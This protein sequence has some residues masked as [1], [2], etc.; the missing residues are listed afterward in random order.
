MTLNSIFRE[1]FMIGVETR[2]SEP[3]NQLEADTNCESPLVQSMVFF[4]SEVFLS[5]LWCLHM[6]RWLC[7]TA[8]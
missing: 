5:L 4:H 3:L 1:R 6:F 8:K 2:A 7:N